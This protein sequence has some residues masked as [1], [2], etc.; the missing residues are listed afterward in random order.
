MPHL[1]MEESLDISEMQLDKLEVAPSAEWSVQ[2]K[3][4][5]I[6]KKLDRDVAGYV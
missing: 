6:T 2:Q 1:L 5:K 3:K 4:M